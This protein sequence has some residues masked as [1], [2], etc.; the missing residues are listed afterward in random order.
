MSPTLSIAMLGIQRNRPSA[1]AK[2]PDWNTENVPV[3]GLRSSYQRMP[4]GVFRPVETLWDRSSASW[5]PMLRYARR[6]I[7]RSDSESS[8]CE[9]PLCGMH[10]P[11][12]RHAV[13]KLAIGSEVG[14]VKVALGGEKE[15][16]LNLKRLSEVVVWRVTKKLGE[17]A[18]GGVLPSRSDG[19]RL[20]TVFGCW[21]QIWVAGPPASIAARS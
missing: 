16:T 11:P 8:C 18:G 14:P 21:K 4:D 10:A 3:R 9:V 6:Y 2:V 7:A 1:G 17:P 12:F 13:E 5:P 20:A 15:L 19:R